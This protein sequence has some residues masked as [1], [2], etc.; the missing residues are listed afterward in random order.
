MALNNW[1]KPQPVPFPG[2]SRRNVLTRNEVI[3]AVIMLMLMKLDNL[4]STW[5]YDG[6]RIDYVQKCCNYYSD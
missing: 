3:L 6:I 4:H 5:P 2:Q 1:V